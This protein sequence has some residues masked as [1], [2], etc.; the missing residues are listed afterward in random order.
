M[1]AVKM[2]V[3]DGG[4]DESGRDLQ[5][6]IKISSKNCSRIGVRAKY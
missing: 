2:S 1:H 6:N 5:E 4:W 3:L